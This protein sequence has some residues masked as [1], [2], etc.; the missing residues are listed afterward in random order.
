MIW[1]TYG[2]LTSCIHIC[3]DMHYYCYLL[4][5]Y[6]Y[7]YIYIIIVTWIVGFHSELVESRYID[8]MILHL[9][10]YTCMLLF[11]LCIY[12]YVYIYM[13]VYM[14]VYVYMYIYIY[15][16]IYIYVY[17]YM[18]VYVYMYIYIKKDSPVERLTSRTSNYL[19]D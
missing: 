15:I 13:C 2:M 16:Y 9:Y 8:L 19:N 11:S 3:I 5:I 7:V 10:I 12:T 1:S 6:T 4:Y 14:C 18:C 17:I